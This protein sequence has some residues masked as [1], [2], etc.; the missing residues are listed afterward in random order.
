MEGEELSGATAARYMRS[1][2]TPSF[3]NQRFIKTPV[4]LK[5]LGNDNMD[6]DFSGFR[7]ERDNMRRL[8]NLEREIRYMKEAMSSMIEKQVNKRK[9]LY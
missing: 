9:H 4:A 1:K 7:E 2:Q 5:R 8:I 3:E 6:K